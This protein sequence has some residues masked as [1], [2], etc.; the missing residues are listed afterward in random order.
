M[1]HAPPA[2][3][4]F[5]EFLYCSVLAPDQPATAV[6]RILTQ[7][8]SLNAQRQITGLLVFDGAR[9]CQHIEGPRAEVRALMARIANDPRH[10]QVQVVHEGPLQ[11]R[12]YDRFDMGFAEPDEPE[13][14]ADLH[15]HAGPAALA[16]FLA[17]RPRFDISG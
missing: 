15:L 11:R 3:A 4:E 2:P 1:T 16:R 7:A 14:I 12:R 9:F 17:L 10:A 8:R 13:A 6:P 5:H